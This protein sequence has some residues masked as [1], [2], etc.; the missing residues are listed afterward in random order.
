MGINSDEYGLSNIVALIESNPV[1]V[2]LH[3]F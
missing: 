2:R 3:V 1:Y